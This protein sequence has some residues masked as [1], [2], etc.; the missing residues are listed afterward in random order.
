MRARVIKE[1]AVKKHLKQAET[2]VIFWQA[3]SYQD[4]LAALEEIRREYHRWKDNVQPG[5]Q[6]V[7]RIVKR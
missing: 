6:R 1:V 3:L 5:F 2:D 7:Y 4:R